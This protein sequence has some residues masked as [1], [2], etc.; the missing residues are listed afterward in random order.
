VQLRD[1]TYLGYF[2]GCN[3]S[4]GAINL[5]IHDRDSRVGKD[6]QIQSIG[7]KTAVSLEKFHVDI[8]GNVY[9]AREESRRELA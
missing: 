5:W 2:S 7:V 6:G 9:P 8:L 4:T 1:V 3:R